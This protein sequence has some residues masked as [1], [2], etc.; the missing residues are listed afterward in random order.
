MR[1]T[2]CCVVVG[3]VHH[4]LSDIHCYANLRL[5]IEIYQLCK[6]AVRL[7][8]VTCEHVTEGLCVGWQ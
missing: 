5:L 2:S 4:S 3:G 6:V 7:T 1:E 8:V